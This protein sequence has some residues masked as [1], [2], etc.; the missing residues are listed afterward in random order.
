MPDLQG[1]LQTVWIWASWSLT[2]VFHNKWPA[3]ALDVPWNDFSPKA[4]EEWRIEKLETSTVRSTWSNCTLYV[5]GWAACFGLGF[6]QGNQR[7]STWQAAVTLHLIA[8][9]QYQQDLQDLPMLTCP[10]VPNSAPSHRSQCL[11]LHYNL[12]HIFRHKGFLRC[13]LLM[14]SALQDPKRNDSLGWPP[15]ADVD[16]PVV[17]VPRVAAHGFAKNLQPAI[18]GLSRGFGC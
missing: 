2:A 3:T 11:Q 18:A 15:C 13:H 16:L 5:F 6:F 14:G 17:T 8:F 4:P 9:L 1:N 10:P 12:S 7:D